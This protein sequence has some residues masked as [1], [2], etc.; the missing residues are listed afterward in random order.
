MSQE[1]LDLIRTGYA[2]FN[3]R[4]FAAAGATFHP[5]VEWY[6][7]LGAVEGD[8]YRGREAILRMW[9][10]LE[11]GFGGTLRVE[12]RELID[13]G[14]EVVAVVEASATGSGSGLEVHQT[15]AQLARVQD[16]LVVR[17][18]P[19]PDREAALEAAGLSE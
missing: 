1:N 18:E 13:C 4:D 2:A 5:Q 10:S 12:I 14:D 17:V 9:S 6:P 19:Y 15:W 8:V 3:R 11:E 16:G 7:Y